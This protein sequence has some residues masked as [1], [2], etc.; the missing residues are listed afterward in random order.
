MADSFSTFFYG[1][2]FYRDQ[3]FRQESQHPLLYEMVVPYYVYKSSFA[4]QSDTKFLA[5]FPERYR[6]KALWIRHRHNLYEALVQRDKARRPYF[7]HAYKKYYEEAHRTLTEQGLKGR[8]L[9]HLAKRDA[10]RYAE[11]Y[12]AKHVD[13]KIKYK[14]SYVYEFRKL[15][16][17]AHGDKKHPDN[18]QYIKANPFI[19]ELIW[20]YERDM[21]DPDGF[22]LAAPREANLESEG[23]K[24]TDEK[25]A[26]T[27]G[28]TL[29]GRDAAKERYSD[30][31]NYIAHHMLKVPDGKKVQ[32][33][34]PHAVSGMGAAGIKDT[35]T[36]QRVRIPLQKRFN[37]QILQMKD[38]D[39]DS[40]WKKFFPDEQATAAEVKGQDPKLRALA[41]KMS[42]DA[43]KDMIH[44][45]LI[46]TPPIP[47]YPSGKTLRLDAAGEIVHE[48]LFLPKE[49]ISVQYVDSNGDPIPVSRRKKD[50]PDRELATVLS[51]GNFLRHLSPTELA[52]VKMWEQEEG[53]PSRRR[54]RHYNPNTGEVEAEYIAVED[55]P[56]E[57][58]TP[59]AQG[60]RQI[61]AGATSPNHNST[62]RKPLPRL[63]PEY[64][65]RFNA[66][67][68]AMEPGDVDDNFKWSPNPEGIFYKD[69][70]RGVNTALN[71]SLGGATPWEVAILRT[72]RKDIHNMV[73]MNLVENLDEPLIQTSSWRVK[74]AMIVTSN[75]AQQDWDFGT[76]RKR[77][78]K[79]HGTLEDTV[80]GSL[81]G[82][83]EPRLKQ[84]RKAAE[85]RRASECG[86]SP[87]EHNLPT[88]LCQ[89]TYDIE[90]LFALLGEAEQSADQAEA[91]IRHAEETHSA[92]VDFSGLT[93]KKQAL[94]DA[95]IA[96][97]AMYLN[98]KKSPQEAEQ[99]AT[100]VIVN[101]TKLKTVRE[102]AQEVHQLIKELATQYGVDPV[103]IKKAEDKQVPQELWQ[104]TLD[105]FEQKRAYILKIPAEA[106]KRW[107]EFHNEASALAEYPLMAEK[108]KELQGEVERMHAQYLRST[109]TE[110]QPTSRKPA[111]SMSVG[112]YYQ[113]K[114]WVALTNHPRFETL[115]MR[116]DFPVSKLLE[117]KSA[118]QAEISAIKV[119][120][121]NRLALLGLQSSLKD[122]EEL[123]KK[124]GGT[125]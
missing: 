64:V 40:L 8:T 38:S 109:T 116:P 90:H 58:E 65:K 88:G 73:F 69:I 7:D 122:I 34:S 12:A 23:K 97:S 74:R 80:A 59:G 33:W 45:G 9:E 16:R 14:D 21:G 68:K 20:E 3:A 13:S 95:F 25:Y 92:H 63:H 26:T 18:F 6:S 54:G 104:Q 41:G 83:L 96:L 102:I 51:P 36:I 111:S 2:Y 32:E 125:T 93:R 15:G 99:E 120:P 31:L 112:Q 106:L 118:I 66:L 43:I 123:I 76:R 91:E 108:I 11:E 24:Q 107:M 47:G 30:W 71:S 10:T 60:S 110:P 124:K 82:F 49:W 81:Q 44:R 61:R 117:I 50:Q 94:R 70:V 39:I 35:F 19:R 5:Q 101:L 79:A 56:L 22:D 85:E 89:F 98:I 42:W 114:R 55:N 105:M 119:Q 46:H 113:E 100:R 84:A 103:K 27:R 87:G 1:E 121:M 48:D 67:L 72:M 115:V 57:R 52:R 77:G 4:F 37:R 75:L 78:T 28:M 86:L 62:G 53:E 29:M 17:A